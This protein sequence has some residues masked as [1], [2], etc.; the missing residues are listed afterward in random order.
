[1]RAVLD[2]PVRD[3]VFVINLP[4]HE[5]EEEYGERNCCLQKLLLMWGKIIYMFPSLET[6]T[7]RG[8]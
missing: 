5:E 8:L 6:G 1:M 2:L 4:L 7:H 3:G